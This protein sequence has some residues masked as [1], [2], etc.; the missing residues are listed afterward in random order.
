MTILVRS[1]NSNAVTQS[2]KLINRLELIL[3]FGVTD[4][5]KILFHE[6]LFEVN[7]LVERKFQILVVDVKLQ[8]NLRNTLKITEVIDRKSEL[9][10]INSLA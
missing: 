8:R 6:L 2:S 10:R 4:N 3:A 1:S 7:A 9:T 5:H